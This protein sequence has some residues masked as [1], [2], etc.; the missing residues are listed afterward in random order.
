MR[1]GISVMPSLEILPFQKNILYTML[2]SNLY[3]STEVDLLHRP[4]SL[5]KMTT[6]GHVLKGS[7]RATVTLTREIPPS[8][9]YLRFPSG[10]FPQLLRAAS[11]SEATMKDNIQSVLSSY[12]EDPTFA[13]LV[14]QR[15]SV[16]LWCSTYSPLW[17]FDKMA[18]SVDK[19]G[20]LQ[21]PLVDANT[22][23]RVSLV[24]E[25]YDGKYFE[26]DQGD[27]LNRHVKTL[28]AQLQSVQTIQPTPPSPMLPAPNPIPD[29]PLHDQQPVIPLVSATP[30]VTATPLPS[31]E[32]PDV[33]LLREQNALLRQLLAMHGHHLPP[34]F[35]Q[36]M[37]SSSESIV[38]E[39]DHQNKTEIRNA[40]S[41]QNGPRNKNID[42]LNDT[43]SDEDFNDDDYKIVRE[44]FLASASDTF[45][46]QY[47]Q[48]RV[49]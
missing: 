48:L 23:Q 18:R 33:K 6:E 32:A 11:N 30:S 16:L 12:F 38:E 35:E 4:F 31:D 17:V 21:L 49:Q 37:N 14:A 3:V 34:Q 43:S 47:D 13:V 24:M 20:Y 40:H 27:D 46:I 36:T 10:N 22:K 28:Q 9:I 5:I 15:G 44:A 19:N 8:P 26:I 45:R 42:A 1:D 29:R 39:G 7:L 2:G 41:T 25:Y